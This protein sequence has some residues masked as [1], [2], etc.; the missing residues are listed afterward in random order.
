MHVT[1]VSVYQF[2]QQPKATAP[3]VREQSR[4][5][6]QKQLSCAGTKF[7]ELLTSSNV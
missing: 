7:E 4:E 3:S 6:S 1:A 5:I 2:I